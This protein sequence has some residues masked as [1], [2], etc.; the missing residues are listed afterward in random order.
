MAT[1]SSGHLGEL[2][3]RRLGDL[4]Q[5]NPGFGRGVSTGMALEQLDPQAFFKRIDMADNRC[6]VNPQLSRCTAYRTRSRHIIG[7]TNFVPIVDSHQHFPLELVLCI[8]EQ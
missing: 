3:V 1:N 5:L 6:V 7:R 2:I 8:Y 4:Q